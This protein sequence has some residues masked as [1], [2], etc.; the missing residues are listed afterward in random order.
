MKTTTRGGERG[1]FVELLGERRQ[2]SVPGAL[3]VVETSPPERAPQRGILHQTRHTSQAGVRH[4]ALGAA[5]LRD[6]EVAPAT[7]THEIPHR[8]KLQ[9]GRFCSTNAVKQSTPRSFGTPPRG[10]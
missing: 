3:V 9:H 8:R 5:R 10:T 2:A 1:W 6:L 7:R 4:P